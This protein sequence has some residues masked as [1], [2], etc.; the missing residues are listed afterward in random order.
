MPKK[1]PKPTHGGPRKGAG[2]KPNPNGP[3]KT[4][5]LTV[6]DKGWDWLHQQGRAVKPPTSRGGW[7]EQQAAGA[8]KRRRG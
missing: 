3:A 1:K 7:I 2:R 5:S 6:S 4:R 8:R